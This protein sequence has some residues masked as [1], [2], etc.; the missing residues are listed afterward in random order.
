M[1]S[2]TNIPRWR[3]IRVT[4][5]RQSIVCA[6]THVCQTSL[7][8]RTT[9]GTH[10]YDPRHRSMHGLFIAAGPQFRSGTVV[11]AFENVHVYELICKVLGLQPASNDGSLA[12][13]LAFLR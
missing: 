9:G 7:E 11:P 1:R 6:A 2:K 12:E 3:S 13:T 5:C 8:L 4:R 10:G